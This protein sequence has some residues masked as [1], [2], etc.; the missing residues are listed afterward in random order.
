M[1]RKVKPAAQMAAIDKPDPAPVEVP[2]EVPAETTTQA[3]A[4]PASLPESTLGDGDATG[5]G[6]EAAAAGTA[7]E[8]PQPEAPDMASEPLR[9]PEGWTVRVTGP[10]KGRWRAGRKFGPEVVAIPAD[11]L[12]PAEV[13]QLM[14]DPELTVELA[15]D[16]A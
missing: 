3:T 1:A 16:E 2:V 15:E 11:E 12:T 8:A 7:P 13:R 4:A 9:G 6:A 14:A 10:A 5:A